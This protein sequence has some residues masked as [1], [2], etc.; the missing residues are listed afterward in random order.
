METKSI[1]TMLSRPGIYVMTTPVSMAFCEVD[2][3][4]RCFQLRPHDFSQ[5]DEL[6][7]GLWN[8]ESNATFYGPLARV[9]AV[10]V[11]PARTTQSTA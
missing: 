2:A 4:G 8:L 10:P 5:A 1:D 11:G 3:L 9:D 6:R 7:P